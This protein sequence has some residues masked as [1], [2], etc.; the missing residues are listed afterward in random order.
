MEKDYERLS[1][2]EGWSRVGGGKESGGQ[3]VG[4]LTF[5]LETFV[6]CIIQANLN[7]LVLPK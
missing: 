3:Q 1:E 6:S 2:T 4:S 5:L 7:P